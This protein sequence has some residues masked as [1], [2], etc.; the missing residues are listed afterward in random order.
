MIFV[1]MEEGCWYYP[2][3]LPKFNME[4]KHDGFQK[5][6]PIPGCHL[7]SSMLNFERVKL[8]S[9]FCSGYVVAAL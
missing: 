6:S 4:P 5:E 8:V 9:S 1:Q 2:I 3:T 7:S